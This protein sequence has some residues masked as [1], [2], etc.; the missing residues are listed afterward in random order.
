[1]GSSVSSE[2][3]W[4]AFEAASAKLRPGKLDAKNGANSVENA[5]G[6]AWQALAD[7]GLVQPV[8]RRKYKGK[9]LKKTR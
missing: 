2:K 8:R 4:Q 3:L 1:M 9:Q 5:Y 7:A 6:Q